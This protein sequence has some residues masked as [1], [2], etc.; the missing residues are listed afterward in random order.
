MAALGLND[1]LKEASEEFS[2]YEGYRHVSAN[3]LQIAESAIQPFNLAV[4]GRM[5]AGKSTLINALIGRPLAIC[6]VEEATATLNRICFGEG[7]QTQ[8]FV[9]QWRDGRA[10]PFPLADLQ[11]WTGKSPEVLERTKETSFL[12]L[13]SDSPK[14]FETQIVDTPG[15]GSAVEEHEITR[16]FLN[17]ET[18]A[19]S[20]AEGGKADAIVYVVPPVGRES[21]EETLKIFSSGRLPNSD[22]YNSVA[23]LHKWDA[24]KVDNP[25]LRAS[26]KSARLLG[27]LRGMVADVL[28]VSGPLALAAQCAPNQFFEDLVSVICDQS[29]NIEEAL[30]KDDWWS[31]NPARQSVRQLHPMPWASF[32]LLV[33][34]LIRDAVVDSE[35]AR[36]TCLEESGIRAFEEFLQTKFFSKASIIKQCQ[37]LQ[38]VASVIEPALR[39]LNEEANSGFRDAESAD[40]AAKII[41]EHDAGLH[42]WLLNTGTKRRAKSSRLQNTAVELDRQWQKH[43]EELELSQMDLQVCQKV[44]ESSELFAS[45]DKE[46]IK[47]I[48]NHLAGVQR[49]SDLGRGKIPKISEID[50]LINN[51]RAMENLCR[52][53]E[54]PFFE[55]IVKRLEEIHRN[56]SQA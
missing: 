42:Q 17:P 21:D 46:T 49:R 24:L 22:P 48:C 10:E 33:R 28:P 38:R 53:R 51:Y 4:V 8:Q 29:Q 52:N 40:R 32:R 6:G 44:D 14:L 3:L 55:H 7:A 27:D 39:R 56:L 50:G 1:F 11:K 37:T 35:Q 30:E 36:L 18:I 20:I 47:A 54:K 2:H 31:E 34:I 12:R 15:T 23:V 43:R 41:K 13:F 25:K 45:N 9:V 26:E 16:E 19:E 5:K